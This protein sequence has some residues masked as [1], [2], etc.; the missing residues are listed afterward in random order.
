MTFSLSFSLSL[1]LSLLFPAG[2]PL[3]S[4][5]AVSIRQFELAQIVCDGSETSVSGCAISKTPTFFSAQAQ[6][7][8]FQQTG[9]YITC[10]YYADVPY[11]F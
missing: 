2:I 11:A 6:V 9:T 7:R 10:I 8:C 1:P 3:T 5:D 4:N